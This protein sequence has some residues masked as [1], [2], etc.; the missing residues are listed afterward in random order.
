MKLIDRYLLREYLLP[1]VY[2]L[3]AFCMVFVIYDLF[4]HVADFLEADTPAWLIVRY[5][6]CLLAPNLEYL[7]PAALLLATLYTLWQLSRNNELTAMRSSGVSLYR[8]MSPFL[9]VGLAFT[10]LTGALKE[11]VAPRAAQ[12]AADFNA[13]DFQAVKTRFQDDQHFYNSVGHRQW[14]IGR[15]DLR[16][17]GTLYRI[18]VDQERPDGIPAWSIA[19]KQALWLDGEWWFFDVFRQDYNVYGFPVGPGGKIAGSRLGRAYPSFREQPQD[20]VDE[21]RSWSF[22]STADMIR[23]LRARPN[24]SDEEVARKRFDIHSRLAMPWACLIVTLFGIPAGAQRGRQSAL[25]GIFTAVAVFFAFYA[26]TQ[27]G[28]LL[29]KGRLIWPWLGAW[30]SNIVFLTAGLQMIKNMR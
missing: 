29:G 9:S 7:I 19:A 22:L 17:P 23:Y 10:V 16:E 13:N 12:W 30:L 27:V 6:L 21:V 11:S 4:D 8:L 24:L 1:I 2:C 18:T 15:F 28:V 5:Y 25:T 3:L 14:H 20:F 26:L